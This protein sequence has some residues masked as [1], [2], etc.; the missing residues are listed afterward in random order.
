MS[1]IVQFVCF[2][3]QMHLPLFQQR[4]QFF[5]EVNNGPDTGLMCA[6]SELEIKT[7]Q[8]P[9]NVIL[10]WNRKMWDVSQSLGI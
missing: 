2:F 5:Q 1:A 8:S 10:S 6:R 9:L 7:K 4:L 3:K